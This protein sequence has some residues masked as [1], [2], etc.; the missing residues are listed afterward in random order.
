MST[1]DT[2][3]IDKQF[4]SNSTRVKGIS[5]HPTKP[6]ILTSLSSGTIQLWN[7]AD[8]ILLHQFH[9]A[10]KGP[11]R[12]V[13][14]NPDPNSNEFISGGDDY[15]IRMW[16]YTS[17]EKLF[18]FSGHCDYVRIVQYYPTYPLKTWFVSGSD[19]NLLR[20]WDYKHLK[21]IYILSSHNHYVMQCEWHPKNKNLLIS[22]SLDETIVIWNISKLNDVYENNYD[23]Y[24]TALSNKK[25]CSLEISGL[26][27]QVI[28]HK[29]QQIHC[30]GINSVNFNPFNNLI[31]TGADDNLVGVTLF[32]KTNNKC[33]LVNKFIGHI[34]NVSAVKFI[35]DSK[36]KRDMIISAGED[37][38]IFI[39]QID[40][41]KY[42][43]FIPVT[44]VY[45]R[46]WVLACHPKLNLFAAGHDSGFF[47]FKI[48]RHLADEN[49]T[50]SAEYEISTSN[51][52]NIDSCSFDSPSKDAYIDS[53]QSDTD[54]YMMWLLA[55]YS[56]MNVLGIVL[57]I[58]HMKTFNDSLILTFPVILG[59]VV[60]I[61][62]TLFR[63]CVIS[64]FCFYIWVY[65][66][67]LFCPHFIIDTLQN[68]VILDLLTNVTKRKW[69]NF[70]EYNSSSIDIHC[71]NIAI[72]HQIKCIL[73]VQNQKRSKKTDENNNDEINNVITEYWKCIERNI[74]SNN[75][76]HSFTD[77]GTFIMNVRSGHLLRVF[78]AQ[79]YIAQ[80]YQST[81]SKCIAWAL[82]NVY[83]IYI[84]LFYFP[85]DAKYFMYTLFLFVWSLIVMCMM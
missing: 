41:D 28:T 17:Y 43:K 34:N 2:V 61:V 22:C 73:A 10:H 27:P 57:R 7:Y 3:F 47:I 50:H 51:N 21:P 23:D 8:N 19:D 70:E 12:S 76:V 30:R 31:V 68:N 84:T 62:T 32:D 58:S 83:W 85:Y 53:Q 24:V 16:N 60:I 4:V 66:K 81:T 11:I 56:M 77:H 15:I 33:Y 39:W 29:R 69:I 1:D 79:S 54:Y 45:H 82:I 9:N 37:R 18:E 26:L 49:L 59:A 71:F 13:D 64:H 25:R 48:V 40:D 5:F 55:F 67:I 65:L 52:R 20:L 63:Y 14:F 75:C 44:G 46:Y 74:L 72:L 6:L 42:W 78:S 35:Y 80:V 36:L 38:C